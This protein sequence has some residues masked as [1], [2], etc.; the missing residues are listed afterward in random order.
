MERIESMVKEV[1]P[2]IAEKAIKEEIR[3]LQEGD[4]E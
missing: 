3:K 2:D 1:V 4:K